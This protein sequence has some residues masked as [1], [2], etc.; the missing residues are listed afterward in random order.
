M[1]WF[2]NVNVVSFISNCLCFSASKQS[3]SVQEGEV[4]EFFSSLNV[5]K[6]TAPLDLRRVGG[7]IYPFFIPTSV[8]HQSWRHTEG[9]SGFPGEKT[10][11]VTN[12]S[13]STAVDTSKKKMVNGPAPTI[14]STIWDMPH[15]HQIHTLIAKAAMQGASVW[16]KGTLTLEDLHRSML[17]LCWIQH[18]FDLNLHSCDVTDQNDFWSCSVVCCRAFLSCMLHEQCQFIMFQSGCFQYHLCKNWQQL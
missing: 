8:S 7:T 16:D 14:Q 12:I 6:I 17:G 18:T 4:E 5:S 2:Q 10:R 3:L 15:Y 1:L 11:H 13:P 9:T